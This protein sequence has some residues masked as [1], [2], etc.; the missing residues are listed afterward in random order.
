MEIETEVVYNLL[1]VPEGAIQVIDIALANYM[2]TD[3]FQKSFAKIK[4]QTIRF[5]TELVGKLR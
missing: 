5:H 2:A 1:E 3:E 4:N